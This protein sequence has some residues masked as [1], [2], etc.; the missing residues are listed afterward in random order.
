MEETNI[1][2]GGKQAIS[3]NHLVSLPVMAENIFHFPAGLPA[4][5]QV[6][7]FV[8]LCPPDLRPFFI[9]QALDPKDLAFVCID[10][11]V[12]CPGYSPVIS[13]IDVKALGLAG[14]E[15]VFLFSIVTVR[16]DARRITTNL[17]GP[18]VINVR[19]GIGR[20]I[21]CCGKSYPVQYSLWESAIRLQP[22][23]VEDC[24]EQAGLEPV[25]RICWPKKW[26]QKS[27]LAC[28]EAGKEK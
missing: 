8:L 3:E 19:T 22:F 26:D 21:L 23:G 1:D 14:R 9:M 2:S 20:Q 6:H 28:A 13:E 12:I 4:F 25:N 7:E 11:F 10:P 27:K 24:I 18:V 5:E 17:Q 16:R 15:D